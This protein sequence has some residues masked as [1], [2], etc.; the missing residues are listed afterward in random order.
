MVLH[1]GVAA[2]HAVTGGKTLV[3]LQPPQVL[4]EKMR[5]LVGKST[6]KNLG[7]TVATAPPVTH[8]V[9]ILMCHPAVLPSSAEMAFSSLRTVV[10]RVRC[11]YGSGYPI[12]RVQSIQQSHLNIPW[13][14]RQLLMMTV[15][16]FLSNINGTN[17]SFGNSQTISQTFIFGVVYNLYYNFVP[18]CI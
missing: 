12:P 17:G 15:N 2:G 11:L 3:V 18:I 4:F 16:R 7:R 1:Q 6:Q 5:Q 8:T 9:I 14:W 13:L 10:L